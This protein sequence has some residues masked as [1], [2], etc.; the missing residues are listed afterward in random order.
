VVSSAHGQPV[1]PKHAVCHT[2]EREVT[3]A[4]CGSAFRTRSARAVYCPEH[5]KPHHRRVVPEVASS[6]D[7]MDVLEKLAG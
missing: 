1:D 6:D 3:C 4:H 5:R 2:P 7:W